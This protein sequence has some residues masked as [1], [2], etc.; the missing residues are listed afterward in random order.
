M[1]RRY[2]ASGAASMRPP[3]HAEVTRFFEGLNAALT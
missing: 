3:S 2:N 1:T